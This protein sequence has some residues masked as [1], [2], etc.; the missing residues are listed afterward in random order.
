MESIHGVIRATREDICVSLKN[1]AGG[2]KPAGVKF[3]DFPMTL[4]AS[5]P[6]I[7]ESREVR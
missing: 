4:L 5:S 2:P 7:E 3:H 1:N 6:G